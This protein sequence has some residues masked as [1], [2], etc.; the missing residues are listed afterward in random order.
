[1]PGGDVE[2]IGTLAIETNPDAL[3]KVPGCKGGG[4]L[5]LDADGLADLHRLLAIG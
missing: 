2:G 3:I 5:C 1:M 4:F